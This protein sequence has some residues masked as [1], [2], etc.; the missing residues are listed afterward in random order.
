MPAIDLTIFGKNYRLACGEGQER[1]LREL[2]TYLDKRL[3]NLAKHSDGMQS[4]DGTLQ[5]LL[6]LMLADELND[7]AK[8]VKSLEN[9][10]ETLKKS[11]LEKA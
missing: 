10:I 6:S 7:Y 3:K 11:T 4:S 9:E 8:Q 1:H 2:A 5:T